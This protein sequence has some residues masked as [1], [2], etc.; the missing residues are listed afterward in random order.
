MTYLSGRAQHP[1]EALY[2]KA[3]EIMQISRHISDYLLPDVAVLN[4]KGHEDKSVYFTGDI[5]RYSNSLIP[6][7][8]KAENE[9]FQDARTQYISAITNLTERLSKNCERL[10]NANSNGKEFV[11]I[12]RKEIHKFKKLQRVWK[13]TL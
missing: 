1:S 6:N 5:I 13:L 10:E 12:L 7:L 8:V 9:F 4:D 3:K 11:R 2:S